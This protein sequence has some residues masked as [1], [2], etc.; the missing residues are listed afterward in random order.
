LSEKSNMNLN[1]K[2]NQKM[3]ILNEKFFSSISSSDFIKIALYEQ[4]NGVWENFDECI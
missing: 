2:E 4:K 3:Y 1:A